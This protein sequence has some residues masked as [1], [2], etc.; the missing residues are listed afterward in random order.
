MDAAL[1]NKYYNWINK[2]KFQDVPLIIEKNYFSQRFMIKS[3]D[4]D[5]K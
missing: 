4:V 3:V 2:Q 5:S 1:K